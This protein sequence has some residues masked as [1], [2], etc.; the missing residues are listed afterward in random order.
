MIGRRQSINQSGRIF[1]P[2]LKRIYGSGGLTVGGKGRV[3][4]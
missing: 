2:K 4:F 1:T 3:A